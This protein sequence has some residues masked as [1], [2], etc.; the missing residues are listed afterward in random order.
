MVGAFPAPLSVLASCFAARLG[1]QRCAARACK[2]W[3]RLHAAAAR[4][5][6][7][8]GSQ[9][10]RAGFSHCFSRRTTRVGSGR[11]PHVRIRDWRRSRVRTSLRPGRNHR[12]DA[13][14]AELAS[15]QIFARQ[16]PGRGGHV[17]ESLSSWS[18]AA[19]SHRTEHWRRGRDRRKCFCGRL[20]P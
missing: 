18:A 15:S 6:T 9:Q 4:E 17:V 10:A 7:A 8:V 13:E 12:Q 5:E 16:R 3:R 11:L 14:G 1:M 2:F 20:G 19:G